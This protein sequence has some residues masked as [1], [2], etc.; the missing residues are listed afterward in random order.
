VL[1]KNYFSLARL[2]VSIF[3]GM[4]QKKKYIFFFPKKIGLVA[5]YSFILF[6]AESPSDS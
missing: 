4:A 2:Y 5:C 3:G 6:L 1:K